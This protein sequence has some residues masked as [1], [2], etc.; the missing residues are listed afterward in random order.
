M[1]R[2]AW[3]SMVVLVSLAGAGLIG[4]VVLATNA[5]Q[6]KDQMDGTL[7]SSKIIFATLTEESLNMSAEVM[8]E[9]AGPLPILIKGGIAGFDTEP[10]S[11]GNVNFFKVGTL[12]VE[13]IFAADRLLEPGESRR[14]ALFNYFEEFPTIDTP[15][16]FDFPS[17]TQ[18]LS[19]PEHHWEP[20][21]R[22]EFQIGDLN[23][24]WVG[25]T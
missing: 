19:P 1:D 21:A 12:D 7:V 9:N 23:G 17:A 16:I 4:I 8:V 14:V 5:G 25:S 22:V 10:F 2:Y 3:I 13:L 18:L 20:F 24:V 11:R 15:T 6:V